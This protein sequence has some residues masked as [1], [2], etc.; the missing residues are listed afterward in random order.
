VEEMKGVYVSAEQMLS[1][2]GQKTQGKVFAQQN[3]VHVYE[4]GPPFLRTP[5]P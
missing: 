5:P 2:H 3:S 4:V 1:T